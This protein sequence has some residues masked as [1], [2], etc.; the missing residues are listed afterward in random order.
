MRYVRVIHRTAQ[1]LGH[2]VRPLVAGAGQQ[3]HEFL[4]AIPRRQI[5]CARHRR[6]R[7]AGNRAQA[8]IARQMA[9]MVIIKFEVIHIGD[10]HADI[11][12]TPHRKGP[13]GGQF[14]VEG[15]PVGD[16]RQSIRARQRQQL[17]VRRRQTLLGFH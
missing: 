3:H 4:P 11:Q 9:V 16:P 8:I 10:H 2:V 7:V 17:F 5:G 12:R 14:L 13:I 1:P 6:H 15:A